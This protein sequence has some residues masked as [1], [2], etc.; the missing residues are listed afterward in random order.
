MGSRRIGHD[1]DQH[2]HFHSIYMVLFIHGSTNQW[3]VLYYW[4]IK[5]L[6]KGTCSVQTPVVQGLTV[7]VFLSVRA[8]LLLN[9]LRQS[10]LLPCNP[11]H[12][13]VQTTSPNC[14]WDKYLNVTLQEKEMA[15][16][17]IRLPGKSHGWRSLVIC[18]PWGG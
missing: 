18:S 11:S 8:D 15:P 3:I 13:C 2:L 7:F 16:H 17:S 5:A 9:I 4:K 6:F 12:T 10:Y 14:T 1:R